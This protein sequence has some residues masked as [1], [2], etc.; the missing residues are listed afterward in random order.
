MH[1]EQTTYTFMDKKELVKVRKDL[2]SFSKLKVK[3]N[4]LPY[5]KK[6]FELSRLDDETLWQWYVD[7]NKRD[8]ESIIFNEISRKFDEEK[9]KRLCKKADSIDFEEFSENELEFIE[10]Y[11]EEHNIK[12]SIL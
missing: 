11:E 4:V 12:E 5:Q 1:H 2:I 9:Y 3:K 7:N 6:A 10:T 8:F